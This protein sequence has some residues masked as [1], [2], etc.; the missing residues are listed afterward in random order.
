MS[1][2]IEKQKSGLEK[3]LN[4]I[5]TMSILSFFL[6]LLA[7]VWTPEECQW[8]LNRIWLSSIIVLLL[9][10]VLYGLCCY[11]PEHER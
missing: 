8:I 7:K 2:N 5:A 3:F 9:S 11:K 1:E 6:S 10:I 4:F